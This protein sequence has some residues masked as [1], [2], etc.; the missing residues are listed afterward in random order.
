MQSWPGSRSPKKIKILWIFLI[1]WWFVVLD[2]R[3]KN[4][5]KKIFLDPL[6]TIRGSKHVELFK[7]IVWWILSIFFYL[8]DTYRNYHKKILKILLNHCGLVINPKKPKNLIFRTFLSPVT[9][10]GRINFFKFL[11]LIEKNLIYVVKIDYEGD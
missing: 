9:T 10:A 1:S 4:L 2:S 7:K 8:T 6:C 5:D 11:I 3:N